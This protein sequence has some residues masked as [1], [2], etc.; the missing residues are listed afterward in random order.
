[1][2]LAPRSNPW[3]AAAAW[4]GLGIGLAFLGGWGY[5]VFHFAS[6]FW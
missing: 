3:D 2:G 5:V 6:K 4:I 1:M